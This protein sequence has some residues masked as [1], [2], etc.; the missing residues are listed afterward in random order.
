MRDSHRGDRKWPT[1]NAASIQREPG[2]NRLEG[3][4]DASLLTRRRHLAF[5][6]AIQAGQSRHQGHRSVLGPCRNETWTVKATGLRWNGPARPQAVPP[7][8]VRKRSCTGRCPNIRTEPRRAKGPG[9]ARSG[10]MARRTL[11]RRSRQAWPKRGPP[12]SGGGPSGALSA[13]WQ[14]APLRASASRAGRFFRYTDSSGSRLR[15][16][17]LRSGMLRARPVSSTAVLGRTC[18]VS[19]LLPAT[20]LRC[21]GGAA[22]R[23]ASPG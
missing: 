15:G 9:P 1:V 20:G 5:Q 11:L 18:L 4:D 7:A 13:G 14:Q 2:K 10:E 12:S 3:R 19:P 23:S 21:S 22:S 8:G 6:N 16:P 17:Y